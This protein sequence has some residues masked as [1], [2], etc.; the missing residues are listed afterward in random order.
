LAAGAV[1]LAANFFVNFV[2][3][4]RGKFMYIH[5]FAFRMKAGVTEEQKERILAEIRGLQGRIPGLIET[6]V[7]RNDSPRGRGYE[8]GGV[9]KFASR[10]IFEGYGGHPAHQE[11]LEWLAPLI[12]AIEVDFA[13]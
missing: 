9:M 7:G 3:Q 12:G 10:E 8:I 11:L 6:H 4:V 1:V 2:E 5:M 13:G